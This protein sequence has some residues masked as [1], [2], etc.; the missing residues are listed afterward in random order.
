MFRLLFASLFLTLALPAAASRPFENDRERWLRIAEASRPELVR[1]AVEPI[2]LVRPVRDERAF[3]HWRY[4]AAGPMDSLYARSFKAIGETTVDLG[5][6]VTGY[7]AFHIATLDRTAQ[8]APVKLRFT[9]GE[10]PAEL[11][12]PLD[13]W[14][15]TLSR[16]WMQDET[17]TLTGSDCWVRFP[18]RMSCRYVKIELLGVSWD[19][20]F[21]IDSLAFEA[22][23][24]AGEGPAPL[25]PTCDPMIA[26]IH[27]VSLATLRECMQTVF[28]D[29][30]KRDR[31]LWSGDLYLQALA[32][33][34][35]FGNYLLTKRCLYLFAGLTDDRGCIPSNIFEEPRPHVQPNSAYLIPYSLLF[36]STLLDYLEDSGDRTTAL[37]LW[38]V[39]LRQIELAEECVDGTYLFDASRSPVPTWQFFDWREGL[40][41][42]AAMQAAMIFA[43]DETYALAEALGRE[44]EV[45]RLPALAA[46]M[47]RAA[48]TRLYDPE[49]KLFFSGAGRQLS[50]L[51]QAWM[52]K[53]GV[54]DGKAARQAMTGALAAPD[55]VKPGTPYATHYVIEGLLACGLEREARRYLVDYW[56]GMVDKGADTFWEAYDPDDDFIS[57]YGFSPV[58]SA[59]HAWSCTPVYFIRRYPGIF[60]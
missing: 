23:T 60:E 1:R 57:P 19:Y 41:T 54:V 24:S 5:D 6:H 4:E 35:S 10:L 45:A 59:C 34:Y 26:R 7:C 8:D 18:R 16:G 52:V 31:R 25:A 48:R 58:N 29:G 56:G 30:P 44:R 28:E 3:Q 46:K 51:S 49:R 47:R 37:D 53:A 12:T 22:V 27:D 43:L 21:A 15:G 39:A 20:D 50:V 13:P 36:N 33:K 14:P 17:V 55:V 32:N 38:P 9:F 11:N 2:G 42:Q 40:D